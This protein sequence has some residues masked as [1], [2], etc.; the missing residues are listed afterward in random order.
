MHH[1]RRLPELPPLPFPNFVLYF[2]NLDQT[3]LFS[4]FFDD[5]LFSCAMRLFVSCLLSSI[6]FTFLDGKD[7]VRFTRLLRSLPDFILLF[8]LLDDL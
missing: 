1:A 8:S 2:T 7:G 6:R 4:F 3:R 5:L